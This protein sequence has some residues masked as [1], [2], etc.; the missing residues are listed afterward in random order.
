MTP[1]VD[2]NGPWKSMQKEQSARVAFLGLQELTCQ[3]IN[4]LNEVLQGQ[5]VQYSRETR[6]L[7]AGL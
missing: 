7:G 5:R 6:R 3:V 2:L 4:L 1:G